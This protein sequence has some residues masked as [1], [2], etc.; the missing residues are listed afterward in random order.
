MG[1]KVDNQYKLS[2]GDALSGVRQYSADCGDALA[3]VVTAMGNGAWKSTTADTFSSEL[4]AHKSASGTAGDECASAFETEYNNED[5]QVP[6]DDWRAH[7][8]PPHY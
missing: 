6:E 1:E 2:L 3:S 5:D 8:V 7:W 4:T